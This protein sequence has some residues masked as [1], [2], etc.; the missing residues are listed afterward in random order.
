MSVG[1]VPLS[2]LLVRSMNCS[3]DS[4]LMLDGMVLLNLL[5]PKVTYSRDVASPIADGMAPLSI[6]FRR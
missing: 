6:L 4:A 1:I 3:L 5:P 2:I